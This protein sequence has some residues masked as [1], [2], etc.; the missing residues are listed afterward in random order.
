M[1]AH[2]VVI[3]TDPGVD[4]AMATLMALASPELDVIGLT[5]IFGNVATTTANANALTL[6]EERLSR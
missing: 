2:K 1:N 5:T 6:L 4:D 3:D